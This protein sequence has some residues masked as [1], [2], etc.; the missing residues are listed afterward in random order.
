MEKSDDLRLMVKIAQMYYEQNFTQAEIARALGIYRTSISRMLK[1]VRLKFAY[2]PFR[3]VCVAHTF[4]S[5]TTPTK[6][7]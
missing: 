3:S 6:T 1:K 2:P 5:P 4:R 7:S